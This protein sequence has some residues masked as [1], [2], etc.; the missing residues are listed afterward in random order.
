MD[1]SPGWDAIDAA[2][3]SVYGD[4]EPKHW[5]TIHK[6]M[7]GGPDPLDGISAYPR[8]DP[9]PHWHMVSYGMSELYEKESENPDESGWGFE[10]TFRLVRNPEDET[11]PVWAASM[12][13]NLARYVFNSGNWFEPGHH[14]N[15]N[16]PIAADRDDSDIRAITFV[17]DPELGEI[18]TPHGSLQFL[19]VVG[20]ATEEY[21]AVRQWNSEALMDVLAPHLPL[22]VTDLDRRSLLAD[23]GVARA[24]REGLE[25]DGSSSGMQFVSTAHWDRGPDGTTIKLGALQAPAIADSLRGRLPFGRELTLR[26]EDTALTFVPA[27]EFAI[28]EPDDGRLAIG[29]PSGALDDLVATLQPTAARRPVPSLP[30]LTVEIVPTHMKDQYGEETGEVVG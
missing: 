2:L 27:D 29:V 16:G 14:M 30:G 22:F 25:R 24:V 3:R 12:L 20:L 4:L 19:Q 1:E 18:A 10:F 21:E 17:V 23:P 15:V 8:T 7:L 6:W 9:V 28:E 13:Q 26:T 11:P 5:A